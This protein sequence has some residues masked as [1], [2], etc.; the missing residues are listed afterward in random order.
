MSHSRGKT[1]L[2]KAGGNIE[3]VLE[4]VWGG[5]KPAFETGLGGFGGFSRQT[6]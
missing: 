4:L 2:G 3:L 6:P 5:F 1:G